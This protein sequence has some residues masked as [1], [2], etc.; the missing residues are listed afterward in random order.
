[1]AILNQSGDVIVDKDG[2]TVISTTPQ[3]TVFGVQI[4]EHG[5]N[6]GTALYSTMPKARSVAD[7]LNRK[8]AELQVD[9][10]AKIMPYPV[11]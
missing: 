1:M 9:H 4:W 2:N 3:Y 7:I 11:Y 5:H 8:Y 6:V 10:E